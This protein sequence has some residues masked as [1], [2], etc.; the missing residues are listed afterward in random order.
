MIKAL[1]GTN[2]YLLDAE[3][4]NIRD[5]FISENG[6]E[7]IESY[8]YDQLDPEK[9]R[10]LLTSSSLFSEKRMVIF[11]DLSQSSSLSAAFE[12]ISGNISGDIDV[13]LVESKIDKRKAFYKTISKQFEVIA[14]EDMSEHELTAWARGFIEELGGVISQN[15]L[16]TLVRF[17]GNDQMRLKNEAE[18]LVA[19]NK[20]INEVSINLLVEKKSEDSVFQLLEAALSGKTK[21]ALSILASLESA[22][23]DPFAIAHMLIWQTHILAI[24]YSA[25]SMPDSDI[26][27][28][29]KLKP[30]V[31]QKTHGISRRLSTQQFR[32]II[33]AVAELDINLKSNKNKPWRL[34]EQAIISL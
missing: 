10:L 20:T 3:L 7:A 24:T 17:I 30:Y 31:L 1:I 13:V 33:N 15:D 2:K 26:S 11:K 34:L 32:K 29:T 23:E 28:N 8:F 4:S 5:K 21:L 27:K 19:Y 6:S 22:Y 14:V 16:A 9:L 18:K 12:T 25:K